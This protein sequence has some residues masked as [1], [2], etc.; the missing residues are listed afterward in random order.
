MTKRYSIAD[1]RAN[2]PSI[3][4]D[5][6]AG[7]EVELTRRGKP[8][9]MVISRGRYARLGSER[10]GFADRYR[11]FLEEHRLEEV[12]VEHDHFSRRREQDAGRPVHL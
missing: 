9:A 10:P 11:A 7:N 5:V 1:A 3:I 8:V 6:E 12:G 2:L 4:D